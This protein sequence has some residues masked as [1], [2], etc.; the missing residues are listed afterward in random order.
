MVG[1]NVPL[2]T[3]QYSTTGSSSTVQPFQTIER[4]DVGI[5]LRVKPKI[6][7]GGTVRMGLYQE[8][9]RV[10]SDERRRTTQPGRAVEALARIVGGRRRPAD[11][12][13]RRPHPGHVHRPTDKVPVLGDVQAIGGLFRYD[14]RTR[15]RRICSYSSSRP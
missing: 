3:G 7:E 5:L 8:V 9:S 12:R 2:V 1:Q 11:H 14:T 15:R 13:A 6:T 4:R 10:D